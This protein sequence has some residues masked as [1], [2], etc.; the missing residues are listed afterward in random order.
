MDAH[1][2][3]DSAPPAPQSVAESA[4]PLPLQTWGSLQV[5]AH[6]GRGTYGDVYRAHDPVLDRDVAV[7]LL[8]PERLRTPRGLAEAITEGRLLARVRHPNIVEVFAVEQRR[9]RVGLVMEYIAGATVE[10]RL[11]AEGPL[12][13]D[14]ALTVACSVARAVAG[15][16][17]AGILHR[18]IK[19]RNVM[20]EGTG[21]IVLMDLGI[22]SLTPDPPP[23]ARTTPAYA[24]PEMLLEGRAGVAADIYAVGVLAFHMLTGRYPIE[25]ATLPELVASHRLRLRLSLRDL[26]PELPAVAERTV[27]RALA[28]DPADRHASAADLADALADALAEAQRHRHPELSPAASSARHSADHRALHLYLLGRYLASQGG[29]RDLAAAA[30]RFEAALA[31]DPE[32]ALAAVGLASCLARRHALDHDGG[33]ERLER[34]RRAADRAL[35]IAPELAAAHAVRGLVHLLDWQWTRARSSLHRALSHQPTLAA[36]HQYRALLLL[37]LGRTDEACVAQERCIACDPVC[38]YAPGWLAF[39][40]LRSGQLAAARRTRGLADGAG[41]RPPLLRIVTGESYILQ[42]DLERGLAVL[43]GA[44]AEEKAD[45]LH[46]ATLGWA[47][48][49]CGR[50]DS[51]HRVL[52]GLLR[53]RDGRTARPYLLARVLAG[54]DEQQRVLTWLERAVAARDPLASLMATDPALAS[55]RRE[56]DFLRLLRHM[57]LPLAEPDQRRARA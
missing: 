3:G 32:Y 28:W 18:D 31:R 25:G 37:A 14:E 1:R 9:G 26:R 40:R 46:Q 44:P 29:R 11:A 57:G 13:D 19:P 39:L 27:E 42:G 7:K 30:R 55:L 12:A 17:A 24:A 16:H 54:L 43:E 48:G 23:S 34:A 21:R 22:G 35:A 53:L 8:D 38:R 6:V 4:P 47:Y 20:C 49:V 56:P 10:D 50:P 33:A 51:A 41:L 36:A 45:P 15:L 5:L 52:A 2:R